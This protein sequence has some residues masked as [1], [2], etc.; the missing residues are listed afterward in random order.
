MSDLLRYAEQELDLIGM[1][2]DSPEEM[3]VDMRN[4]ILRMV[5]EFSK[6]EH[7]GLSA[8]YTIHVLENLLKY[9]PLSPLTGA[10]SEWVEVADGLF[11]NKRCHSVFKNESGAWDIDGI[12]FY[13]INVDKDTGESYKSYYT[14][15]SSKVKVVFPYIPTTKTVE[16]LG[17]END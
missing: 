14:N 7:S 15:A 1:T 17:D 16:A 10:D 3:N 12:V 2:A 6:E 4:H 5:E 11:Q 13:D 8:S 9:K